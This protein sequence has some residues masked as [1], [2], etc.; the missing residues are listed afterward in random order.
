[1]RCG[2]ALHGCA[3]VFVLPVMSWCCV[4]CLRVCARALFIPPCRCGCCYHMSGFT[5]RW[6]EC[7]CECVR[8]C[9]VRL[10]SK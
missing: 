5:E 4:V 3:I 7:V 2:V 10:A 9:L 6:C 1:M 8:E